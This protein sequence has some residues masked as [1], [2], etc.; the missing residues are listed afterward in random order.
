MR[1]APLAARLRC[2]SAHPGHLHEIQRGFNISFLHACT[3]HDTPDKAACVAPAMFRLKQCRE[4]LH[5]QNGAYWKYDR[6]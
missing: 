5:I 6:R 1:E 3:M 2:L 4:T